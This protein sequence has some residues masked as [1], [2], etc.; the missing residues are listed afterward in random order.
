VESYLDRIMAARRSRCRFPAPLQIMLLDKYDAKV[1]PA[2]L[3]RAVERAAKLRVSAD[4]ARAASQ[5]SPP[6]APGRST[7]APAPAP[8]P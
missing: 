3:E 5:P 1:N 2:G 8:K 6:F 7:A 4:S